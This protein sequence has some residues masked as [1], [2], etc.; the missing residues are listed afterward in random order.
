MYLIVGRGL[1][2]EQETKI[3]VK[4]QEV[5]CACVAILNL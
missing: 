5:V 3:K 1:I 2:L 4:R